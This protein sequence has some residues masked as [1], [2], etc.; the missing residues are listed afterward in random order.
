MVARG[1]GYGQEGDRRKSHKGRHA[2]TNEKNFLFHLNL[3]L[4]V[5]DQ[6]NPRSRPYP[7]VVL[8][9]GFACKLAGYAFAVRPNTRDFPSCLKASQCEQIPIAEGRPDHYFPYKWSWV[10]KG[11][12]G[13]AGGHVCELFGE[14]QD[15]GKTAYFDYL[16]A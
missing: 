15:D 4:L 9:R 7:L 8:L 12:S 16:S 1:V 14:N 2:N 13:S 11:S 6:Q 10:P 3:L 5:K